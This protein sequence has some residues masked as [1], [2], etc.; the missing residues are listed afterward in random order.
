MGVLAC[1]SL[2]A[3][4]LIFQDTFNAADNSN[5]NADL[6]RQSGTQATQ[7]YDK[8]GSGGAA[9]I[10]GN[11][12]VITDSISPEYNAELNLDFGS[13]SALTS[14]GSFTIEFDLNSIG[15][16]F[17]GFGFNGAQNQP[18][19]LVDA[20]TDFGVLFLGSGHGDAGEISVR[21]G[22]SEGF[23]A[24]PAFALTGLV[25]LTVNT[26]SITTGNDFTVDMSIDGEIVDLNGVAGGNTFSNTWSTSSLY[27]SFDSLGTGS[28][29]FDNYAVTAVPEPSTVLYMLTGMSLL[30][31]G[32][33]RKR[34]K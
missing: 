25:L 27:M 4:V 24:T 31:L 21:E 8:V 14:D 16:T 9:E 7:T 30:G 33:L 2:Q 5:L 3:D 34:S 19:P 22:T 28:S 18:R 10:A 23:R 17:A 1:F 29:T 26:T 6:T 12:L 32:V 11:S 20:S 13:V 15:A